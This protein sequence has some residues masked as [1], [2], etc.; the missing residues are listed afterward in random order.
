MPGAFYNTEY[1]RKGHTKN[2]LRKTILTITQLFLLSIIVILH[3]QYI[4]CNFFYVTVVDG[5][6]TSTLSLW[7]FLLSC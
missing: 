4:R 2:S 5:F 6:M 3:F 1:V 7:F